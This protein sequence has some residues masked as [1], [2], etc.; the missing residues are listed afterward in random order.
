DIDVEKAKTTAEKWGIG[1][2]YED[3]H[4]VIT[5]PD[6]EAVDVTT[7][8]IAH[9]APVIAA[10]EAGKHVL[11]EKP[12]PT[13]IHDPDPMVAA[14]DARGAKS[15]MGYHPTF[16]RAWPAVKNLVDEGVCGRIMGMSITGVSPSTHRVPWF[17]KREFS[18]GGILMDWGIYTSYFI[19]W[20]LG[21]VE[22]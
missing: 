16:G 13:T 21:P 11:C 18:G 19:Q 10:A 22:S 6:V 14:P 4:D 3:Y 2:Y 1:A 9:A 5:H 20:L 7:W 8:P 15:G 12:I 17:L